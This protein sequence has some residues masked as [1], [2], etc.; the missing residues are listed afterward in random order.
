MTSKLAAPASEV[1]ASPHRGRT[2]ALIPARAGSKRVVGKNHRLFAGKPLVRWSIDFALACPGFDR[3][4][5]STDSPEVAN[6]A[7]QAGISTPWLRPPELAS[8][9]ATTLDVALHALGKCEEDGESFDRLAI[10]QPTCPVRLHERWAQAHAMLD[11]PD[12]NAVIGVSAVEQ[13]PFWTYFVDDKGQ[14]TPCFP[15]KSQLR[16]QDLP[17]AAAI[18][19]ALYLIRTDVL[20]SSACFTPPGTHAVMCTHA[21][22]NID[23]DTES[24]WLAAERLISALPQLK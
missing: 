21:H 13:H 3:I 11:H 8:D 23:I 19:G 4:V 7:N 20:K 18:N 16:S 9:T 6:I 2:L 22:E 12:C 17:T 24:D 1:C 14:L 10:L 5:V 15:G